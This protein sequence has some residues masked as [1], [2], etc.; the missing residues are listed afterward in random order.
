MNITFDQL[1]EMLDLFDKFGQAMFEAGLS[2]DCV[3][4]NSAFD[5]FRRPFIDI[6]DE[7]R[8]VDK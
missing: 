7:I 8:S 2:K 4:S 3:L 1:N 5:D 6:I